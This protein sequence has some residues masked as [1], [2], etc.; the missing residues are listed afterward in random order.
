IIVSV[1]LFLYSYRFYNQKALAQN[2]PPE[3]LK[4]QR[5]TVLFK[6]EPIPEYLAKAIRV[7]TKG[8]FGLGRGGTF[9][10]GTEERNIGIAEIEKVVSVEP[11]KLFELDRQQWRY[12]VVPH[13]TMKEVVV[14]LKVKRI[15]KFLKVTRRFLF[16]SLFF[17]LEG[18]IIEIIPP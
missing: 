5:V 2:P 1:P 4:A 7:G 18:V 16:K 14:Q 15:P 17:D 9:T 11:Q 13:P 8:K 12:V 6:T 3:V 10:A